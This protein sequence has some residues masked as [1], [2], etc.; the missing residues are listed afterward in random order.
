MRILITGFDNFGEES[1]NPSNLAIN[2]LPN[3]LKNIE[4]KKV[5]LPTVFKESSTIL[6]GHITA[7]NP[8]IVICVGQAGGRDKVTIE[9]IAINIDDARIA[10]NK[11][12]S[13]VDEIIRK[14]GE[15]AYFSTLPIKALVADL[16]KRDI[17]AAISNTAGT[18]VCNHIMYEALYLSKT[19]FT[20][21]STGFIHIPYIKEQVENKPDTPFMELE[22]IVD[23]LKIIIETS[24]KFYKK[25]DIKIT[26]GH[27]H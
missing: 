9:R 24:V 21:I 6:E 17:P 23:A 5:I 14:D 4:I 12:N 18:F 25:N 16:T 20:D 22:M 2:R 8:N 1:I 15:T 3:K 13:P 10:D 27:E 7:F 11:D 26:G 19:K